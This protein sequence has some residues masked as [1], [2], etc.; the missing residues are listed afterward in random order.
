MRVRSKRIGAPTG[1][2]AVNIA[3]TRERIRRAAIGQLGQ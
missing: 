3:E 1:P 2:R